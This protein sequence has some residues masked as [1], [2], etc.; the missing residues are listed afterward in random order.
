[1]TDHPDPEI[2]S[3]LTCTDGDALQAATEAKKSRNDL[4]F[5]NIQITGG[6]VESVRHRDLKS[7]QA[8]EDLVMSDNKISFIEA[9]AFKSQKNLK[10]LDLSFN[11]IPSLKDFTFKHLFHLKNLSVSDNRLHSIETNSFYDLHNLLYLDLSRNNLSFLDNSFA[12]M[13]NLQYLLLSHNEINAIANNSFSNLVHLLRLDLSFNQLKVIPSSLF[14]RLKNLNF[15]SLA[16]NKLETLDENTFKGNNMLDKVNLTDNLWVCDKRLQPL[17]EWLKKYEAY[18]EGAV[19]MEPP[20]L[21]NYTIQHALEILYLETKIRESPT[22]NATM[23]NCIIS[24]D[25]LV[26]T[27][28]CSNKGFVRLP[29]VLPYKTKVLN[30]YNNKIKSLNIEHINATL[31]SD[32]SFLYLNNNIVDSVKNLE[33]SWLLKNLVALHLSNN[34]LTEIQNYMLD[35]IR[36]WLL[37][38]LYLSGNP[39]TCD[40][41]TVRFQT[42]LQDNY[43]TIRDFQKV[44]CSADSGVYANLP[45]SKLKKSQLCPQQVQLVNYLDVLNGIMAVAIVVIIVKLSYDYW[46]Q[47]QT[48]KLPKF[49]SLNL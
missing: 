23:C 9:D 29:E 12:P 17:S 20:E 41:H 2:V 15:L 14:Y 5:V 4:L 13:K 7:F 33:G 38:E 8:V 37:D 16:G 49:F 40:C 28:D 34:R 47:K 48:G 10:S 11:H 24:R 39:W 45:I 26:V 1:M 31:W 30:L 19:C 35:Q 46:L 27:V 22:C 21:S 25:K 36:G 32:V 6:S 43:R 44:S 18:K 42:W 3:K